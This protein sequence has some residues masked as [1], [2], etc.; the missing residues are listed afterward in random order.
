VNFEK[1]YLSK[2]PKIGKA[3]LS[4]TLILIFVFNT[5]LKGIQFSTICPFVVKIY[6]NFFHIIFNFCLCRPPRAATNLT[7]AAAHHLHRRI[8]MRANPRA[9]E[10]T[11]AKAKERAR[12][13]ARARNARNKLVSLKART[14]FV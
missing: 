5:I 2:K 9:R 12:E 8:P 3:Y 11:S 13:K 7:A 10:R 4:M 1:I 14:R 6:Y